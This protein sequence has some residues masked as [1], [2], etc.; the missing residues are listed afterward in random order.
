MTTRLV[1]VGRSTE[2]SALLSPFSQG[3]V[4]IVMDGDDFL[5]LVTRMDVVNFL[6]RRLS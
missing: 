3:L 5:G 2:L 1:T 6:R 4:P